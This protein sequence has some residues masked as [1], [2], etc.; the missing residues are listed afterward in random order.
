ME[1]S[2]SGRSADSHSMTVSPALTGNG[3]CAA[4]GLGLLRPL[5]IESL[6]PYTDTHSA[7]ST[8]WAPPRGD[9][10]AVSGRG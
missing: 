2:P 9:G 4:V 10:A 6:L 3:A 1:V 5:L 7:P 8:D